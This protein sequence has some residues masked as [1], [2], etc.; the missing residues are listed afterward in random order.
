MPSGWAV[1]ESTALQGP[2]PLATWTMSETI[3]TFLAAFGVQFVIVIFFGG[4]LE[5]KGRTLQTVAGAIAEL[6]LGA[7][8]ILWLRWAK[9]APVS[10]LGLPTRRRWGGDVGFG[11]LVGL[12]IIFANAIL[13]AAAS[14]IATAILGH[15]PAPPPTEKDI[16]SGPWVVPAFLLI[17]VAA[18][19]AEEILF[20]G[21]LFQGLRRRFR[22][23]PAA[24]IS[25]GVFAFFHV[26]PLVIPAIFVSGVILALLY[27][28][29][30][31]LLASMTAHATLNAVAVIALLARR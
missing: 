1:P 18:P 14:G 10:Q 31:S 13:V 16:L 4:I 23:W 2:W 17:V 6:A 12:G 3:T 8:V 21:F 15:Q 22:V 27:E 19:I 26:Y 29:R 7:A 11:L 28:R 20:R 25:A 9:H 24:L 30:R 5:L